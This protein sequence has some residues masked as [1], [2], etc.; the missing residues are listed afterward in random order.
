MAALKKVALDFGL[1]VIP[2]EPLEPDTRNLIQYTI[3]ATEG[4]GCAYAGNIF[5]T[6]K[7]KLW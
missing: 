6:A 1:M 7:L 5:W 4:Y 3:V 2:K